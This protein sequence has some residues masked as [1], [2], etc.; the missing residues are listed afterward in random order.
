M[1]QLTYD[2]KLIQENA[3]VQQDEDGALCRHRKDSDDL[4]QGSEYG[5]LL[6][7]R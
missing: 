2:I 3:I 6:G 7:I 5:L 4:E 1:T